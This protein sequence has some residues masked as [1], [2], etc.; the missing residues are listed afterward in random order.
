MENEKDQKRAEK[1]MMAIVKC[2]EVAGAKPTSRRDEHHSQYQHH[3]H[4]CNTWNCWRN[5][6]I[7]K[8]EIGIIPLNSSE[9]LPVLKTN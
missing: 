2:I 9:I 7:F 1:E 6:N 4:T 5:C 3:Q 8:Y